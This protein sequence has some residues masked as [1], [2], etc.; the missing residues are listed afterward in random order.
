MYQHHIMLRTNEHLPS[1]TALKWYQIVREFAPNNTIYSYE[2]NGNSIAMEYGLYMEDDLPHAYIVP[3]TRDM[4]SDE[5]SFIV[6][7]WSYSYQEDCD[8]EI[9][10][11]FTDNG[12]GEFDNSIHID[13]EIKTQVTNDIQK[14]EHNRWVDN[15][16]HEGWRCGSY[17]NSKQKTHPALKSWDNLPE[18]HRRARDIPNKEV[19]EFLSK[20][21]II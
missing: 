3:L 18:S 7:A 12:F 17:F 13:E 21:K 16:I 2:L 11:Q 15:K 20:N 1:H 19:M 10:N 8:I 4:T 6:E 5:A 14:W 9:S